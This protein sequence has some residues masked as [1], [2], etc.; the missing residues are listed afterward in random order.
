M[1]NKILKVFGMCLMVG[2]L[3]WWATDYMI[4][5]LG[6]SISG[7][8]VFCIGGILRAFSNDV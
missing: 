4:N 3:V 2:G 8:L 5:G 6:G 7:F 1:I